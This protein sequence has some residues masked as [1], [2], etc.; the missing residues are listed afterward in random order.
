MQAQIPPELQHKIM[1]FQELQERIKALALRRQQL[2]IELREVERTLDE[3]KN[4][5]DEMPV[6]KFSGKLLIRVNKEDVVKELS[7]KKETLE[8]HI[9]T[10]EKQEDHARRRFEELR[11]D[12]SRALANIQT[13][14]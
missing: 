9:R 12:L 11:Q 4:V 2:E 3:L 14:E 10:L 13:T 5:S 6:F 1:Q 8:L 7:D